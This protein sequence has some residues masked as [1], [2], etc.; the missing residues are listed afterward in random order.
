MGKLAVAAS[1]FLGAQALSSPPHVDGNTHVNNDDLVSWYNS[2]EGS[3]WSAGHNEF[4][5]GMTFNDARSTLGTALSHISEHLDNLMPGSL[6]AN[7]NDT[8]I[9]AE[10]DARTQWPGLIHPI[11]DQQQCGSCW[12]FSASEVLS[13][14]VAIATGK[15]SP[16]LSPEDMV[17]CDGGDNGCGG[18]M[19]NQAWKYL[20]NTGIV[21]DSCFPY[22]AGNGNAPRCEAKCVDSESFTK[23]KAKNSYAIQGVTNMQKEIMTNG[24]I[25][26]A[27]MVYRS[28]MSYK[29]GVYQ[30]HWNEFLPE[31][32]HAV[33]MVGWGT[34]NG[35]DYWLVANSWNTNWGLDG[36]FKIKRGSDESG[37]ESRG[38]PYAGMPDTSSFSSAVVV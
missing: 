4:F 14:R 15:P 2:I 5:S 18:G 37:I 16:V 12:A 8:T 24:P 27:F 34:E 1:L 31:G 36:F 19:L 21:T 6:Y 38:P 3:T 29:S 13:D 20:T 7:L 25:Q 11:R 28:F 17:S 10:F 32:G 26:V 23:T 30:K 35:V 9:P 33:K 22:T